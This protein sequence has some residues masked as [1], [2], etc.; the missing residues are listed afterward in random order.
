MEIRRPKK[1]LVMMAYEPNE[2]QQ[3]PRRRLVA[4]GRYDDYVDVL[5]LSVLDDCLNG[6]FRYQWNDE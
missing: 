6:G 2:A 5:L 4:V 3:Q 1:V